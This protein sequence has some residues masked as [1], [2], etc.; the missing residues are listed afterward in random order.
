MRL[1]AWKWWGEWIRTLRQNAIVA[2]QIAIESLQKAKII[3]DTGEELIL[4]NRI[5][6]SK[7]SY[8]EIIEALSE[9]NPRNFKLLCVFFEQL[10]YKTNPHCQYPIIEI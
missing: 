1:R 5:E 8:I 2:F 9:I 3:R 10:A 7:H 6:V 4:E